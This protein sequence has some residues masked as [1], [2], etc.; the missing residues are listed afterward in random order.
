VAPRYRSLVILRKHEGQ[1]ALRLS[2]SHGS[3]A[4]DWVG[5]GGRMRILRGVAVTA[6][7]YPVGAVVCVQAKDMKQAWCL[8]TSLGDE[9]LPRTPPT[10]TPLIASPYFST[11][12]QVMGSNNAGTHVRA[13]EQ[14]LGRSGDR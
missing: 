8:A 2:G 10:R 7:D 13:L 11:R 5:K 9:Q 1:Y 14:H 6:E 4:V 3:S 12:G